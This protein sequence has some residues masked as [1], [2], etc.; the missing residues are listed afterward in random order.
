M[1]TVRNW[2][3][4]SCASTRLKTLA[5]IVISAIPLLLFLFIYGINKSTHIQPLAYETTRL[6]FN[7]LNN[8]EVYVF[9]KRPDLVISSYHTVFLDVLSCIPYMIHYIIP[10]AFPLYLYFMNKEELIPQFYWLIGWTMWMIFFI[11]L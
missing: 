7:T 6:H 10:F 4:E 3:R 5:K 8:L 1:N 9:G 11:W 2:N